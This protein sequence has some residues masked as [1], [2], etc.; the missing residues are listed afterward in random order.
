MN[1][2]KVTKYNGEIDVS[3]TKIELAHGV[4]AGILVSTPISGIVSLYE[5]HTARLEH[6]IGLKTWSEMEVD[7]KAMIIALRRINNAVKNLQEEAAI[8]KTQK[9]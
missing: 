9:D 7:E 3:V 2:L 4:S 8:A 6:G 5:E 1:F